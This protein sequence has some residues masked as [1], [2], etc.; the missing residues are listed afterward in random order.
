[1]WTLHIDAF[2][3]RLHR[4]CTSMHFRSWRAASLQH[5]PSASLS[6]AAPSTSLTLSPAPPPQPVSPASSR[7]LSLRQRKQEGKKRRVE[8]ETPF[9]IF[10]EPVML[11]VTVDNWSQTDLLRYATI[12][13]VQWR[14][15]HREGMQRLE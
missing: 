1:M 5:R 6:Y 2:Q 13:S 3:S 14:L 9:W 4:C 10:G 7:L 12:A 11:Q 8:E 15:G